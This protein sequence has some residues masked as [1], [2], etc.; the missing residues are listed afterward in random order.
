[1]DR[2]NFINAHRS[3]EHLEAD[4]DLLR[5]KSPYNHVLAD[6]K[7]IDQYRGK[8]DLP[9]YQIDLLTNFDGRVI[10]ELC[11]IT[12]QIEILENRKGNQL[13]TPDD[14]CQDSRD[15]T[16]QGSQ[17]QQ[18]ENTNNKTKNDIKNQNNLDKSKQE[19]KKKELQNRSI[20]K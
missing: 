4:L 20:R 12:S 18:N 6:L 10:P 19:V 1:M 7:D 9:K 8:S 13:I 17:T 15:E 16:C 3:A 11:D 2:L 14:T 5:K